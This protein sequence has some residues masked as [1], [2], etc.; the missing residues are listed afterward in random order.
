MR[1]AARPHWARWATVIASAATLAWLAIT[2][3]TPAAA[4]PH[5]RALPPTGT[6]AVELSSPS[7]FRPGALAPKPANTNALPEGNVLP[8]CG[9]DAA[10]T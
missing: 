5:G 9:S 4:Q 10:R 6:A 1:R 2:P 8:G 7:D 3:G